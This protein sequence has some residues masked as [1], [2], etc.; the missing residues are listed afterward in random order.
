MFTNQQTNM[1]Q[2]A[3]LDVKITFQA[4][5]TAKKIKTPLSYADLKS[6]VYTLAKAR[7]FEAGNIQYLDVDG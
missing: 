2:F 1:N 5:G 3:G 7:K 6:T 4:T